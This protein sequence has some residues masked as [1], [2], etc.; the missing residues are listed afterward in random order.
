MSI[1]STL[2][3]PVTSII[4]KIIPDKEA[5]AKA[6]NELLRL[7]QEGQLAELD[8]IVQ[9]SK[10][11]TDIN[12]QEAAHKSIFVAGWRP[13][14]GWACGIGIFWSFLGYPVAEFI[15][16]ASGNEVELPALNTDTLFE[17]VLAMLGMGG[18]RTYEK[19]K[20]KAREK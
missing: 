12:K 7:Q 6:K 18:L 16:V 3:G 11:Q 2:I 9:L 15:I 4:D 13:F 8:A 17:L 20:G 14:I 10:G 5:A 19:L 1:L